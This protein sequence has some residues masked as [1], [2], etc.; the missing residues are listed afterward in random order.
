MEW[1]VPVGQN[2]ST[3]INGDDVAERVVTTIA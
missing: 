1:V 3:Q 2:D